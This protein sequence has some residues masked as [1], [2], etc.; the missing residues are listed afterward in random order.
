MPGSPFPDRSL[1]A[2]IIPKLMSSFLNASVGRKFLVSISG[3]F[4]IMFLAVH[5]TVNL[6]LIA[7]QE[8][9][10]MA[11]HFMVTNPAI[12]VMQ[13]LLAA[14]FLLHIA[15]SAFIT[16]TNQGTR[17]QKYAMVDQRET[18]SWPS[19][20]MFV[21]G[22]LILIFLVLHLSNFSFKMKFGE[23]IYTEHG[24]VMVKDAY[25]LVTGKFVIWW[26]ALIYMAG[27]VFL[28]LHLVHGFA[29]AF[30]TLGLSNHLWYRRLTV[31]GFVYA[32]IVAGGFAF[33][34]L[35]FLVGKLAG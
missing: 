8:A 27:A 11:A 18:S 1:T 19:R 33:I 32:V 34:P 13:P 23:M 15:Y 24:G 28:G 6:F 30:Q 10:N 31:A 4:L 2:T 7:G 16:F 20:N 35:W 22:S 3:L 12:K 29:S 5:L 9:Y 25:S 17:P 14:G 26:Y 21:L